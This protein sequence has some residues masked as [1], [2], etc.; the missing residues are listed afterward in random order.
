MNKLLKK[1][2][3]LAVRM[4]L[5]KPV[6]LVNIDG[7]ICSQMQQYLMGRLLAQRGHAI[8]YDLSFYGYGRDMD[9]RQVRNFDLLKAFPRLAFMSV[10]RWKR[11]LY[12]RCFRHTGH[13]PNETTAEWLDQRP[14]VFLGGYYPDVQQMYADYQELFQPDAM[15]L[16]MAN[17]AIYDAIPDNAVAVHIRR[18]D[19]AKYTEAYGYPA[20]VEYFT[21][22]IRMLEARLHHPKFYFFSDDMDYVRRE[23]LVSLADEIDHQVVENG[24]EHGYYDLLLMSRCS[25]HITSKG[26]LGKFAACLNP[27]RGIAIVLKEDRQLGPLAFADKEIIAL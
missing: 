24:A 3:L 13:Y 6:I 11:S 20:T 7:G 1:L 2:Y 5:A 8:R 4:R 17:R 9:G 25:H 14:P 16:D 21:Q 18:G 12:R 26:S 19:L 27:H 22:A 10:P 15:V 23:V